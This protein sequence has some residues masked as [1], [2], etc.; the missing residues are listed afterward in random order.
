L[1][2]TLSALGEDGTLEEFFKTIPGFF[3]SMLV[4]VSRISTS[5]HYTELYITLRN[6]SIGFLR[7]TLSSNSISNSVKNSRLDIYLDA[8]NA[9]YIP[10]HVDGA[11]TPM[12]VQEFGQLPQ[13]IETGHTLARWFTANNQS[14][15]MAARYG[16]ATILGA[17]KQRDLRWVALAKEFGLPERGLHD[18]IRH[19]DDSVLLAIFLHMTRQIFHTDPWN[20]EMLSS[21]PK[22]DINKTRLELQIEFSDLWNQIALK[23]DVTR[24]PYFQVLREIYPLYKAL[25]RGTSATPAA[26]LFERPPYPRC[27]VAT[28]YPNATILPPTQHGHSNDVTP[29]RQPAHPLW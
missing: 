11:L 16:V 4:K 29:Y 13:S 17:I 1:G 2:W 15:A 28:H 3:N 14:I 6:A 21:L 27:N 18:N 22:F 10:Y 12:I 7:R 19:G 20:P 26:I 5:P 9:I 23:A 25:H 8:M 24:Y